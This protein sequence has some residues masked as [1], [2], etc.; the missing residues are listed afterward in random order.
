MPVEFEVTDG[1]GI[2]HLRRPK[3]ANA[4]NAEMLNQIPRVQRQLRR[5]KSIRVV[6]TIGEGKGFCAGSDL[7]EQAGFSPSQAEKSQLLEA[8]V[9]RE[10][11]RLPQPTIACVHGY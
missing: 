3:C 10:F 11:L 2:L 6:I 7:R 5:E 1:V 4:L 9:C 8:K